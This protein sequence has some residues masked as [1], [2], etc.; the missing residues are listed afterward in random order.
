[1]RQQAAVPRNLVLCKFGKVV[2]IDKSTQAQLGDGF[3]DSDAK[4][5]RGHPRRLVDDERLVGIGG[6]E[7][8]HNRSLAI[9]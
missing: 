3:L 8:G 6:F 9:G 4:L 2:V 5:N 7:I 1:M